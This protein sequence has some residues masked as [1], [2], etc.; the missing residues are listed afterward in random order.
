[1][2]S[3]GVTELLLSNFVDFM[4]TCPNNINLG[5]YL[6]TTFSNIKD[7]EHIYN[8]NMV[9][10]GRYQHSTS[11]LNNQVKLTHTHIHTLVKAEIFCQN[12]DKLPKKETMRFYKSNLLYIIN[13][14][15]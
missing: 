12:Y 15:V 13:K 6:S 9:G 8:T 3:V 1:M 11:T 14:R 7:K 10:W 5:M 4:S 2:I